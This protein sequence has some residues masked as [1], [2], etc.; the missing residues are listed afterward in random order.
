MN[1]QEK[2]INI[3][4]KLGKIMTAEQC[5]NF[6]NGI[7]IWNGAANYMLWDLRTGTPI[8]C[9]TAKN[10]SSLKRHLAKDDLKNG[11]VGKTHVNPALR[12][13]CLAQPKGWL[14]IQFKMFST[15]EEAKYSEVSIINELGIRN[16]GGILFNQR[17][18]G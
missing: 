2:I 13:Y 8:Y 17:M 1:T 7:T 10:K 3:K 18:S 14:G 15:N 12:E 5:A 9:G 6:L 16:N 4:T 11:P